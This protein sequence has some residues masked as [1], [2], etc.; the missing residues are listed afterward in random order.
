VN[1]VPLWVQKNL[2]LLRVRKSSSF[3]ILPRFH[4]YIVTFRKKAADNS[5]RVLLTKEQAKALYLSERST[6]LTQDR[7]DIVLSFINEDP[8]ERILIDKFHVEFMQKYFAAL[9]VSPLIFYPII[10]IYHASFRMEYG[11]TTRLLISV[12]R[13]LM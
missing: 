2:R 13:C 11:L 7:Q 9:K 4:S 1:L 12:C 8:S 6:P 5:E 10:N 3:N